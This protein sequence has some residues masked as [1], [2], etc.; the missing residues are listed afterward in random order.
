MPEAYIIDAC[1]TPVGRKD[2]AF[3]AV[4]PSDLGG[5]VLRALVERSGLDPLLVED[6]IFGCVDTIGPQAAD[7]ARCA[8]LAAGLPE[9]VPGV[10]VDRQC[11]SS[12]QAVHFA[13][14][15][16]M[17][18]TSDLVIAGG[19][20]N[21]SMIP[22]TS[23]MTAAAPLGFPHPFEAEGLRARYG[24]QVFTQ[25]RAAELIAER[26]NLSRERMEAYALESH[27]R[28]LRAADEGRFRREIVPLRG[29]TADECP[30]RNAS[31]ER[32]EA[33]MTLEEDGRITAA[34]CSQN[35]DG[36]A[37]LLIASERA[38]R[39]HRLTPRARIHHLG[40]RAG[41]PGLMLTAPI[42]ATRRAL[43][44]TGLTWADID[45]VEFSEAFAS[46]VLAWLDETHADP[47]RVNVNGGAIALGHP[48][49]ASGARLMT[50]L[51]HELERTGGRYGL[52][53][54]CEGG[55]QANV[56]IIERV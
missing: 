31:L 2:G 26:W 30:R 51:L 53:A 10:T 35:A 43:A 17:S 37:A 27:R 1:R 14:Q 48:V 45:C 6:V 9:E 33:L 38:V 7:I 18:G 29:V 13:A 50:T 56:T 25:F 32:M 19:V 44:R 3:R 22:L 47:S 46:V 40:A 36:A 16:V 54:M 39:E 52:Q 28:A 8:W 41:D 20:Q 5:H 12:Q 4:H 49:G 15:A 21:M 11:G 24:D 42:P 34:L 55:G 23:A